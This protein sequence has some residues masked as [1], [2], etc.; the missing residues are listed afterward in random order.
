M[1]DAIRHR[2]R[3]G[4]PLMTGLMPK[5]TRMDTLAAWSVA[6]RIAAPSFGHPRVETTTQEPD[7]TSCR[8]RVAVGNSPSD[9]RV[10]RTRARLHQALSDLI[11]EKGYERTT[12][13]DIL[14][15]AD[16]GRSTFYHHYSTKD[17]LLLSGLRDALAVTTRSAASAEDQALLAPLRPLF[18]HVEGHSQLHRAILGGCATSLAYRAGR[19]MLAETIIASLRDGLIIED[20]IQFD[21]T[22]TYIV[23][24]LACQQPHLGP[25][26]PDVDVGVPQ[27]GKQRAAHRHDARHRTGDP[28]WGHDTEWGPLQGSSQ[29]WGSPAECLLEHPGHALRRRRLPAV[30]V[31]VPRRQRPEQVEQHARWLRGGCVLAALLVTTRPVAWKSNCRRIRGT[32]NTGAGPPAPRCPCVIAYGPRSRASAARAAGGRGTSRRPGAARRAPPR[33]A[34]RR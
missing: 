20:E 21:L 11:A 15:R 2:R 31:L 4:V 26:D 3:Q 5:T 6:V 1:P 30:H 7:T 27:S 10:R 19:R 33:H 13:Q 16:V 22:I 28:H 12:V 14:D 17:D 24:A 32:S 18:E 9:R 23:D 25:A 29:Q 8:G 34:P